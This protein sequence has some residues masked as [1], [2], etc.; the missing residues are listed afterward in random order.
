MC[1]KFLLTSLGKSRLNVLGSIIISTF[2]SMYNPIVTFFGHFIVLMQEIFFCLILLISLHEL[3]PA[4][5][6]ANNRESLVCSLFGVKIF[7]LFLFLLL[8]PLLAGLVLKHFLWSSG[9]G[10]DGTFLTPSSG[11]TKNQ[12]NHNY[13][14]IYFANKTF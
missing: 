12:H 5:I 14:Q 8:L 2:S 7:N 11:G 6:C 13:Y 3:F 4:F 10:M 1:F 9:G